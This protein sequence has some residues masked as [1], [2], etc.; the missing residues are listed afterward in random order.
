MIRCY[1]AGEGRGES[2]LEC[3]KKESSNVI[4]SGTSLEHL[5][6]ILN[7]KNEGTNRDPIQKQLLRSLKSENG[8]I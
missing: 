5:C 6:K 3:I 1:K 4:S 7:G 8:E 2:Q